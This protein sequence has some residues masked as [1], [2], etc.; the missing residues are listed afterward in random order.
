MIFYRRLYAPSSRPPWRRTWFLILASIVM[1]VVV[2]YVMAAL[3]RRATEN[4]ASLNIDNNE[5]LVQNNN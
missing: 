1:F 5:F 2:I 4:D 3:G